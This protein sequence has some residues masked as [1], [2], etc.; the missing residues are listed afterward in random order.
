MINS[1]WSDI[2]ALS[3]AIMGVSAFIGRMVFDN[4]YRKKRVERE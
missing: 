2:F 1:N 4:H 3:I